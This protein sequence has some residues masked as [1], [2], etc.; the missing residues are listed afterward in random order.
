M[1]VNIQ[2]S[3]DLRTAFF[4]GDLPN[5][6]RKAISADK[7]GIYDEIRKALFL[8]KER[9]RVDVSRTY[10]GQSYVLACSLGTI[11]ATAEENNP[12]R[13]LWILGIE[14]VGS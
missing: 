12:V 3:D 11:T 14:K 8:S 10:D 4:L 7:Y 13:E 6:L 5:S 9:N 1:T 2:Y